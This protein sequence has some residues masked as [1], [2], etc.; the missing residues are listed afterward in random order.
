MAPEGP[1][2]HVAMATYNGA[3]FIETQLQSF[4]QQTRPPDAVFVCDDRSSDDTVERIRRFA[5][6]SPF[7][8]HVVVNEMNLGFA[9]N[10][11][12]A[13]SQACESGDL[14]FL[15]DQ[16]DAWHP[17]K[18]ERVIEA[19]R[20]DPTAQLVIHDAAITDSQLNET[21]LTLLGQTRSAGFSDDAFITGACTAVRTGLLSVALPIPAPHHTHDGWLH[22]IARLLG[23]RRILPDTLMRYRR[24]GATTSGWVT[25]STERARPWHV[26]RRVL[27]PANLRQD[28][29]RACHTRLEQERVLAERLESR[30]AEIEAGLGVA[31]DVRLAALARVLQARQANEA[32]LR[33]LERPLP[34][35]ALSAL[36]LYRAGGYRHFEGW[37]SLAKDVVR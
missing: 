14:V 1:R 35:R 37:K 9:A 8:V 28:P 29:R 26:L 12:R 24:H 3:H 32:R 4:A 21:G 5:S 30:A 17:E 27:A 13:L 33:V 34:F 7:P 23:V 16:D 19:F 10:F 36:Q 31:P 6:R 20:A 15:S 11:G 22:L 18:V 25:S 2:V